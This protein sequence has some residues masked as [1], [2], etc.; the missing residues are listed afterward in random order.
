MNKKL[1]T[2]DYIWEDD[3]SKAR[4]FAKKN[5]KNEWILFLDADEYIKNH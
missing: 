2:F 3:F 1:N 4:N 5:A